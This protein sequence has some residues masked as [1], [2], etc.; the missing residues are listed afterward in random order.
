MRIYD[1]S[2]CF[3]YLSTFGIQFVCME[4]W[5]YW[6]FEI[7]GESAEEVDEAN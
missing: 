7:N 6:G 1:G 2:V 4:C 3:S 5:V